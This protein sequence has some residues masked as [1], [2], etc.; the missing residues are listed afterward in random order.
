MKDSAD[1]AHP[2]DP[3]AGDCGDV[4]LAPEWASEPRRGELFRWLEDRLKEERESL[5]QHH[6]PRNSETE[7]RMGCK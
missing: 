4:P 5:A 3:A 6:V 1:V 7:L 2:A